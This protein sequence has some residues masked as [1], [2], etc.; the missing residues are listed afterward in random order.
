MQRSATHQKM[1]HVSRVSVTVCVVFYLFVGVF[2][3][4]TFLDRTSASRGDILKL[5]T[6][7]PRQQ[8]HAASHFSMVMDL[9]RLGYGLAIV[10]SYPMM[11]FELRHIFKLMV[12][13]RDNMHSGT[14]RQLGCNLVLIGGCTAIA[15][16]VADVGVVFGFVGS[17]ISPAMVFIFPAAFYLWLQPQLLYPS[18]IS[19][20]SLAGKG[21]PS[22]GQARLGAWCLLLLLGCVLIPTSLVQWGVELAKSTQEQGA[23]A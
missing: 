8:S 22:R 9:C 2:G 13:G 3:Y 21:T 23:P 10:F 19:R 11:L 4:L 20:P 17:T 18:L 12:F 15:V 6:V 16:S 7:S 5:Y 14:V 1:T